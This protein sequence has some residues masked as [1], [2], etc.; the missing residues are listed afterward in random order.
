MN[1]TDNQ[2]LLADIHNWTHH[3]LPRRKRP[4]D[5]SPLARRAVYATG[6]VLLAGVAWTMRLRRKAM[7][8]RRVA[9]QARRMALQRFR[10]A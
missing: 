2:S 3:D 5:A 4:A 6:L 1:N 8:V 9:T 7:Q 10:M